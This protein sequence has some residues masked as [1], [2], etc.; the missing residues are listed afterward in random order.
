MRSRTTRR[1][2]YHRLGTRLSD[3]D[4]SKNVAEFTRLVLENAYSSGKRCKH[5]HGAFA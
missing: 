1:E 5:C 3:K 2:Y 4:H